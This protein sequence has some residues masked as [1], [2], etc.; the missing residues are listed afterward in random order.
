MNDK[1][2]ILVEFLEVVHDSTVHV[3]RGTT[4]SLGLLPLA[5]FSCQVMVQYNESRLLIL[6]RD[7]CY[8]ILGFFELWIS[9]I[10][11]LIYQIALRLTYKLL[12]SHKLA[13]VF[14]SSSINFIIFDNQQNNSKYLQH[15]LYRHP[16][17]QL[18][19]SIT[20]TLRL[21][22]NPEYN[23]IWINRDQDKYF[24]S[25]IISKHCIP[26]LKQIIVHQNPQH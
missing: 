8:S 21:Q 1:P 13:F 5:A 11:S 22:E 4:I 24:Y 15:A 6:G 12:V 19:W 3:I 7:T 2:N 10:Y 16:L 18:P 17:I 14:H 20:K 23:I 26:F 25:L 9:S